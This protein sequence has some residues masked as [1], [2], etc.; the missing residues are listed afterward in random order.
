MTTATSSGTRGGRGAHDDE[1]LDAI[2]AS[3]LPWDLDL[4][5]SIV[6]RA[7][8]WSLADTWAVK[9][10][11]GWMHGRR[12]AAELRRTPGEYVAVL[13]VH[14][15]TEL[16]VQDGRTAEVTAGTAALWDGVRPV[17]CF[18]EGPLTKHTV[19]V[20]RAVL[21]RALP[22]LDAAVVRTLPASVD[23]RLLAGWLAVARRQGE[24][25]VDAG[26]TVERMA[27]DLLTSSINHAATGASPTHT[28]LLQR[29]KAYLDDHLADPALTLDVVARANA[30][31]LRYLHLLFRDTGQT[32]R[33]YLR[34]RRLERARTLLAAPRG[35]L[36]V[37]QVAARSG[38]DSPSSFS[39]AY[40]AHFGASPRETRDEARG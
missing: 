1:L 16:L 2:A 31:S 20:P 12:R 21:D 39:R 7:E 6:P 5:E 3:H 4:R 8:S 32:A 24:L 28:V 9:C 14:S 22:D 29:V 27:I 36:S 30:I 26:R 33:E 38:F 34:G 37:A 23:L 19:F 17:E 25:D 11:I 35:G 13:M 15:G 10:R 40:R 18:T